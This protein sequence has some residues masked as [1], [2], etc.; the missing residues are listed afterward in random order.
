MS[1]AIRKSG[2]LLK[3]LAVI[4]LAFS[5]QNTARAQCAMTCN[6]DVNVSLPSPEF[7]CEITVTPDMVLE[8][9]DACVGPYQVDLMTMTGQPIPTS[10]TVDEAYIG[11]TL[12]YRVT[13]SATGNLCWGQVDVEDK[14]GPSIDCSDQTVF[15]VEDT[16]AMGDMMPVITDCSGDMTTFSID[17]FDEVQDGDCDEDFSAIV[18]RTWVT[19]DNLDNVSSC[20]Q[21]ITVERVSLLDFTPTCPSNV[22]LQCSMDSPPNTDPSNTGYPFFTIEGV[23][24]PII[25]GADNFCELAASFSDEVFDLCGGGTKILRTWTVYDWCVSTD[26]DENPYNCIQVIKTEDN[27]PPVVTCPA[28]IEV[29]TVGSACLATTILPAPLNVTDGCSDVEIFVITPQG[30]REVGDPV[31]LSV[32]EYTLTYVATDN[33]GNSSSCTTDLIVTD[34]TAP[35]AVCDEFTIVALTGDGTALISALVFDDGSEDNCAVDRY[36]ARRMVSNCDGSTPMFDEFVE[37]CCDDTEENVM[38]IFRVFDEADNF[39]ECMVEVDVQDKLDPSVV[40]PPDKTVECEGSALNLD[41]LS[42]EGEAI[43][44]DNCGTPELSEAVTDNRNQCG[45]GTVIRTFTATDAGGGTGTCA[46]TLTLVNSNPFDVNTV[47]WPADYET[48]EC[49]ASIEPDDLPIQPLNYRRPVFSSNSC[50]LIAVTYED[51]YLPINPPACYKI[52]RKWIVIDWCQ[53]DP[54]EDNPTGFGEWTQIIKVSDNEAPLF[55][56]PDELIVTSNES[57]C[58]SAPVSFPAFT[59]TDCSTNVDFSFEIDLDNDGTIDVFGNGNDIS[60]SYP[61][62]MHAVK[63]IASDGCGNVGVCEFPLTITD[64]KKPTPICVNGVAIE[65]MPMGDGGMVEVAADVMDYG[66]IDNCTAQEDLLFTLTPNIFDCN[67]VGTNVVT[68]T[69]TDEAGN[70]D[71]CETYIIIQDNMN[72]CTEGGGGDQIIAGGIMSENGN[73]MPGVNVAVSGNGPTA[74]PSLTDN[75]GHYE[76][77]DLQSG[78]DYTVQPAMEGGWMNGVSTFDLVIIRRHILGTEPLNSPYKIIAADVNK[79]ASV[80]TSDIISLRRMILGTDEVFPNENTSYRFVDAGFE[81]P[82]PANPWETG[83]PE[84][85]N[86]NNLETDLMSVNFTAVKVGDV[87]ATAV[88]N[89]TQEGEERTAGILDLAIEDRRITA[90][91]LYEVSVQ[92]TDYEQVV[93]YQFGLKFDTDNLEYIDVSPEADS[94]MSLDNFGLT[95]TEQGI[96]LVS[97]DKAENTHNT[98]TNSLFTITFK[99]KNN[100]TLGNSIT[101]HADLTPEAYTTGETIE[102]HDLELTFT[103]QRAA[104]ELFQNQ[105]NPFGAETRINFNLPTAGAATLTVYD[106][107]GKVLTTVQGNYAAGRNTIELHQ[108]ELN[109]TGVLLYQLETAAGT[110]VRKMIV[111]E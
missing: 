78:Y 35:V 36:E 30:I 14:L 3:V 83:F 8:D 69:V 98:K 19:S 34:N 4:L 95:H 7:G 89:F 15:C 84:V 11:Q 17:F 91:E 61:I 110:A 5:V 9:P 85:Y 58:T 39:N 32:G 74:N 102:I 21:V 42:D 63:V 23:E 51:T 6:D 38:I 10:P 55:D 26:T 31:T 103:P 73:A 88:Y 59:A 43:G 40:C 50:D 107:D 13:D 33:C 44:I 46:Q 77:I 49:G 82:N 106:L 71:F 90:G 18:T 47:S 70:S 75:A 45:T 37:F 76:F 22:T 54:N 67:D 25:P 79:S 86:V 94:D 29:N 97:R 65:L 28:T 48:F 101:L 27:E 1:N 111:T 53:Y 64:G 68:L 104:L 41:D 80:T 2:T 56:C 108:S 72:L 81:F 12:M 105:P 109:A 66:S 60:G 99:A 20:T 24:Y 100:T 93:G 52:L 92:L 62:G 16:D 87:N 96:L 57:D